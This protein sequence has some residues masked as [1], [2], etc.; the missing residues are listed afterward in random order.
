MNKDHVSRWLER[1]RR[2]WR[3]YLRRWRT[4]DELAACPASELRRIAADV[5]VSGE[6]LYRLSRNPAGPGE[7]LPQRLEL[8]G[9]DAEY[10]RREMPTTFRDLARVCATCQSSRRCRRDLARGD[11]Q[12][13]LESYCLNGRTIDQLTVNPEHRHA[14]PSRGTAWPGG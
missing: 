10:V 3:Y 11:V 5:G 12:V 6:E 7:L 13:G 1:L 14:N 9:I 4:L 2:S 8:L